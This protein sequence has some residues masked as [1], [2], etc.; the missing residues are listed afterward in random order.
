MGIKLEFLTLLSTE[1]SKIDGVSNISEKPLNSRGK[2]TNAYQIDFDFNKFPLSGLE[3]VDDS[4]LRFINMRLTV[5]YSKKKYDVSYVLD[6]INKFNFVN[7]CLKACYVDS[8]DD[9]E[10]EI[11]YNVEDVISS[12][13][14]SLG[15]ALETKIEMIVRGPSDIHKE[16]DK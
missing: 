16:M 10:F 9:K 2:K 15:S 8:G 3:I 4:G 5:S 6:L 13:A 14:N 1:L 11:A 7:I 12:E